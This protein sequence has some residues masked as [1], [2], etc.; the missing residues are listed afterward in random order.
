MEKVRQWSLVAEQRALVQQQPQ[1]QLHQQQQEHQQQ[2]AELQQQLQ[3]QHAD[4]Q[5]QQQ[6]QHAKAL[7]EDGR[8]AMYWKTQWQ[9][10]SVK[11][12]S[13]YVFFS[14]A[15]RSVVGRLRSGRKCLTTPR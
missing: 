12:L 15:I 9:A 8:V 5:Q 6:Q 11:G 7:A 14:I 3:Q 4:A 13:S 1:A 10:G 2:M